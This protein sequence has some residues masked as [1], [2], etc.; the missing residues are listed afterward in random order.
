MHSIP[1]PVSMPAAV[2]AI[3]WIDGFQ[4]VHAN[5]IDMLATKSLRHLGLMNSPEQTNCEDRSPND[6]VF[7]TPLRNGNVIVEFQ[8][9]RICA[10]ER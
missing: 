1:E 8:L 10:V 7:K 4:A 9:I 2:G 5:L 3:Q 6:W